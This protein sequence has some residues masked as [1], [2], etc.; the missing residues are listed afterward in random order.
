V[1]GISG[2]LNFS[3]QEPVSA[4]VLKGMAD[5][6][7]HR[8][9]DDEG[10][11]IGAGVG[12]GFRRLSIIDVEGGHQPMCNEDGTV[13]L[14]FNGEI[15]NYKD[16][17]DYL[18][19]KGHCFRTRTDTEVILHLYEEV[20]VPHML[21]RLRG[22]FAFAL[23]DSREELLLLAR[24]RVGIKPLYYRRTRNALSFASEIKGILA[25]Q[26][27]VE[28]AP[29]MIDRFLTFQYMPGR[30]TLFKGIEKLEP[31]SYIVAKRGQCVAKKYW[32]LDFTSKVTTEHEA[33]RDLD[34]ALADA[35]R[36]HFNSD[37]PVGILLSGGVDSS[38]VLSY[39]STVQR[40]PIKTFTL[41]FAE[42]GVAD[43]R[44]YARLA[45]ARCGSDHHDL[46]MSAEQFRDFLPDYVWQL[47]EPVCE[48]PGIA[49][50]FVSRLA[51]QSVKVLIAGEGGDEAFGGYQTYR[52][53]LWLERLKTALGPA[54]RPVAALLTPLTRNRPAS[55]VGRY[56]PLLSVDF[57]D[58]YYSR[59]ATPTSFFNANKEA[60]YL[61]EF[62]RTV[63][64]TASRRPLLDYIHASR[65]F[66]LVNRMLYIDTKTWL[67]D[68]LLVKAD[69]IT[70]ANSI[71]LRVPFLDHHVLELAASLPG[72]YKVRRL[73]TKYL[74]KNIL[75]K[76]VPHE[77]LSRP[78]TGFSVP[79]SNWL[80]NEL[81]DWLFQL[82][83][84]RAACTRAYF[85]ARAVESLLRENAQ[86][87]LY[88]R[89]VFSLAVLEL[90]HQRFLAAPLKQTRTPARPPEYCMPQAA[91]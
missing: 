51:S 59:A 13:W 53:V 7:V 6:M 10:Y 86:S 21:E 26:P 48:P 82:L 60:L 31:A 16:L 73:T 4:D 65:K 66:D 46:T 75:S 25:D 43:E 24:D 90:W 72:H 15:Y 18:I 12:L 55:R 29:D 63:D 57:E 71:E 74:A 27:A 85:D 89:E 45:A 22:M 11:Y 79:Y 34:E 5:M 81:R 91:G 14:V 1:C 62:R 37:V 84:D 44:P 67:P 52:S 39:A 50:H 19:G 64:Q 56:G 36:L 49:L 40:Q 69:K 80:T 78:K 38:A 28:I 54:A 23:W 35:V 83:L 88:G 3:R 9:P 30:E 87:R 2:R 8:G 20:G 32:D 41:G 42:T 76:R 47:E 68:D 17:T 77:I 61:P 58:Y 70:M 33:S